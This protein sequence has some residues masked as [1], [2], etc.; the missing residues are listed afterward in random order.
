MN[1][2]FYK[3][4]FV[5]IL[6]LGLL[7]LFASSAQAKPKARVLRTGQF[8][9]YNAF[10]PQI[11]CDTTGQD[12]AVQAGVEWPIP[13]FIDNGNGTITDRM[14]KL[15]WLK[16]A[17]CLGT[18]SR[19]FDENDGSANDG[20]VFWQTALV[21]ANTLASGDCGLT[22]A[23]AEGDWRLPNVRELQSLA[24]YG[25]FV[26]ARS[27][28]NGDGQAGDPDDPFENFE[29]AYWSSTTNAVSPALAWSVYFSTGSVGL[30]NKRVSTW[31]VIAV[32]GGIKLRN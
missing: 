17:N 30:G 9:C 31:N 7:A 18:A 24:D 8:L 28:I 21:F 19:P 6:G 27:N 12:G 4:T 20:A 11:P 13:R 1:D 25:Y 5:V 26:P 15:T 32:R 3:A 10:G 16:N 2:F 14:T 22:D 29:N 23:S